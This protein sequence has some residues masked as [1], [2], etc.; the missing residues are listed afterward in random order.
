MYSNGC[1]L[2]I[3]HSKVV[4][5]YNSTTNTLVM[6]NH[7]IL[8]ITN[9]L[10]QY[11]IHGVAIHPTKEYFITSDSKGRIDQWYV[12]SE[13]ET[14]SSIT[15][16]ISRGNEQGVLMESIEA[17]KKSPLKTIEISHPVC[18]LFV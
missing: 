4:F 12:L 15:Q 10:Q 17:M 18:I 8:T 9:H 5:L 1:Y 16:D 2:V 11:E 13:N 7:V 6:C 3:S 14:P